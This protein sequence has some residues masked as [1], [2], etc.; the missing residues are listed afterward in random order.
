MTQSKYAAGNG[1][2]S[3]SH[4]TA[5]RPALEH[6]AVDIGRPD[7]AFA[8]DARGQGERKIATAGGDVENP[9][10][11]LRPCHRNGKGLPVAVQAERH[12]VVHQV[13]ALGDAVED[14]ADTRRLVGLVHFGKTEIDFLC[15]AYSREAP[16]ACSLAR[17]CVQSFSW[18]S[19][20]SYRYSQ[21]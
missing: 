1:S 21:E 19:P 10:A 17:Y 2:R 3:P 11:P 5:R 6:L 14:L 16:A 7:F 8:A 12:E 13:V 18:F 15:H 9:L 20:S 4:C